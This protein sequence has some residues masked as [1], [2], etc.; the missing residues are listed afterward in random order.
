[1]LINGLSA[2]LITLV[3]EGTLMLLEFVF[4][5]AQ[6]FFSF[7]LKIAKAWNVAVKS[8]NGTYNATARHLD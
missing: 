2:H 5:Q 3:T 8:F 6:E 4:V 7:F 1:M